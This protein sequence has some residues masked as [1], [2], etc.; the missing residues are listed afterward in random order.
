MD[1]ENKKVNNNISL[2]KQFKVPAMEDYFLEVRFKYPTGTW[3][4]CIPI[5]SRYQ[6]IHIPQNKVDVFHYAKI[7]YSHL[8][9]NILC[10]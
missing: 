3:S 8:L 7:C 9:K 1:Y 6:G 10:F 2:L 4:G 5:S